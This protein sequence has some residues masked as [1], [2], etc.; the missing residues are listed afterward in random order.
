MKKVKVLVLLSILS[1]LSGLGYTFIPRLNDRYFNSH[2]FRINKLKYPVTGIDVSKHTGKIDWEEIRSQNIDFV[3]VKA[4]EGATYE[5][6]RYRFNIEG[7]KRANLLTGVYHFY[8][9][10]RGGKE[11]ADNFLS[12]INPSELDFSPVLDVEEWGNKNT[13][14]KKTAQ[15]TKEIREFVNLVEA[16]LNQKMIIYTNESTFEK[17]IKGHFDDNQLWICTFRS[18]PRPDMKWT[19]WQYSHNGKL[20]GAEGIIDI[21]TFNGTRKDWEDFLIKS[22]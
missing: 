20:K 7:A 18:E 2:G 14:N 8:R 11:Q 5:D 1:I 19:F 12:K 17:Y 6:P 4:T 9:F 21:N 10:N 13:K 15:I 22:K 3:F 16:K